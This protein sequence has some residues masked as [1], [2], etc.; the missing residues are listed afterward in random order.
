ME[1]LPGSYRFEAD[2]TFDEGTHSFG[3][4]LRAD[5]ERDTGYALNFEP[6]ASRVEFY[7]RPRM[8][9]KNFNDEGLSRVFDMHKRSFHLSVTVDGTI[10]VAYID[11]KN[12]LFHPDVFGRWKQA[13][14]LCAAWRHDPA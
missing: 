1:E 12:C 4:L 10:A 6:A 8:D 14:L 13:R 5:P 9:Y 7:I 11:G 2:V 3:L